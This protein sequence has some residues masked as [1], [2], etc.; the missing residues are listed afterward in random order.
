M[1]LRAIKKDCSEEVTY[2]LSPEAEKL[3]EHWPHIYPLCLLPKDGDT[4]LSSLCPVTSVF[5]L[6]APLTTWSVVPNN[7]PSNS[8]TWG[9]VPFTKV[10]WP[11]LSE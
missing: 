10:L 8:K 11:W 1:S 5:I 3:Y 7:R 2:K 9:Q 6:L 4:V